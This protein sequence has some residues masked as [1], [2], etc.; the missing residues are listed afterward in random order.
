MHR[1]DARVDVHAVRIA[2]DCDHFRAQL[3]EHRRRDVI[4]GT[5]RAIDDDLQTLEIKLVRERALA[6]LNVAAGGIA[7]AESLAELLRRHAGYRLPPRPRG[8]LCGPPRGG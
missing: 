5:V 1:S 2:A 4:R 3:V 6:E 8:R 7:D